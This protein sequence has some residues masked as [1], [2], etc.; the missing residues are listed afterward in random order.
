MSTAELEGLIEQVKA[1][2]PAERGRLRQVMD[3]LP[4]ETPEEILDRKLR[5]SGLVRPPPTAAPAGQIPNPS[6]SKASRCPSN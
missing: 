5:E 3:G 4:V 1:P 2:S 6:E